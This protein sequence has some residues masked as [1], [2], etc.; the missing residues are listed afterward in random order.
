LTLLHVVVE[1][2]LDV[3]HAAIGQRDDRNLARDVGKDRAGGGQLGGGFDL[4]SSGEGKLG[5]VVG[6]DGDQVH[7][8]HLNDLGR[9][10][11]AIA[12][13]VAFAA[14]ESEAARC[15]RAR[16]RNDV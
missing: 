11:R 12:F 3:H 6:V 8:G 9:R 13:L 16:A 4:G 5:Y 14:G 7:V 2:G 15:S 10:R 1:A